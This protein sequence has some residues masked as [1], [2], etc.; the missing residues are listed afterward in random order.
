MLCCNKGEGSL[1]L[2]KRIGRSRVGKGG[3]G[4]EEGFDK[5]KIV[6]RD[7]EGVVIENL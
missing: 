7:L 5:L 1:C 3:E 4:R 2:R 6:T